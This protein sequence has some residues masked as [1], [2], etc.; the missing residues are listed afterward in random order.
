MGAKTILNFILLEI[1]DIGK[2]PVKW[3]VQN[4]MQKQLPGRNLKSPQKAPC[5]QIALFTM[6]D[7][8]IYCAIPNIFILQ[9]EIW[10]KPQITMKKKIEV[11]HTLY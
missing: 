4:H 1:A 10:S 2:N 3:L 11:I 6:N 9:L 7:A 8:N 5:S